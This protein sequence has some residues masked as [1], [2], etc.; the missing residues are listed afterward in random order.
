MAE[1][2][3]PAVAYIESGGDPSAVR[4]E[5]SVDSSSV[6]LCQTML[7]TARWLVTDTTPKLPPEKLVCRPVGAPIPRPP[8]ATTCDSPPPIH[9]PQS[10]L[11][12]TPPR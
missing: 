8:G 10:G 7:L 11:P 6:G 5:P 12:P 3:L 9:L 1:D 4:Y 2:M